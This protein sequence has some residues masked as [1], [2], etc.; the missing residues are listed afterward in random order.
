MNGWHLKLPAS[1]LLALTLV[2]AQIEDNMKAP[3]HWSLWGESIPNKGPVIRKMFQFD[4]VIVNKLTPKN[5]HRLANIYAIREFNAKIHY[6]IIKMNL[7]NIG[8]LQLQCGAD[9]ARSIFSNMVTNRQPYGVSFVIS[10]SD[11]YST[12]F[13]TEMCAISWYIRP[14]FSGT[15]LYF[16]ISLIYIFVVINMSTAIFSWQFAPYKCLFFIYDTSRVYKYQNVS[17]KNIL[18][19][20]HKRYY[21]SLRRIVYWVREKNTSNSDTGLCKAFAFSTEYSIK[22]YLE[23]SRN[24]CLEQNT[25]FL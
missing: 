17:D 16:C 8:F 23:T 6:V 7:Y 10:N 4:D 15:R 19:S 21:L 20:F 11:W 3:R 12:W 14:R 13:T 1:R 9:I 22:K 5:V 18:S 25:M 2:Q 24:T